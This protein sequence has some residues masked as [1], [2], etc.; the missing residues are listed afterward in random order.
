MHPP[1]SY[2]SP[3]SQSFARMAAM[4]RSPLAAKVVLAFLGACSLLPYN[5]L[6]VAQ[7]YFNDH[8]FKGMSFPFTSILVGQAFQGS[9]SVFLTFKGAEF[10][11]KGRCILGLAGFCVINAALVAVILLVRAGVDGLYAVSLCIVAALS[12]MQGILQS[13]VMGIAGYLG[14]DM[15]A[16]AM[17]GLGLSGL[18]SFVVSLSVEFCAEQMGVLEETGEV[19]AY[20]AAGMFSFCI[21][22]SLLSSWLYF[23]YLSCRLPETAEALKALEAVSGRRS[24]SSE[25]FSAGSSSPGGTSAVLADDELGAAPAR[26]I[27]ISQ[28][29]SD[30]TQCLAVQEKHGFRVLKDVAPQAFNIWLVFTVTLFIFPGVTTEWMPGPESPY[31]RSK[32]LYGTLITGTFSIFDVLSRMAAS[33]FVQRLPARRLWLLVT[34]RLLFIPLF[35]L[36]QRCPE[37]NALWGSDMGRLALTASMAFTNG[38]LGSSAMIFGPASVTAGQREHAGIA[39]TCAMIV[40]L[41]TGSSL[42]PLT[43]LGVQNTA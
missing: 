24:A 12:V 16:A 2:A 26:E 37:K 13:T 28:A 17:L 33:W 7:P 10:T 40:G 25:Q 14:P 29:G 20:V 30:E 5:C 6:L 32:Q 36:G 31:I 21:I 8:A 11:V 39:M 15:S 23:D 41:F 9:T 42:A 38:L 22:Y 19:G 3:V 4:R 34:L 27:R 43:Q 1:R 35:I 18:L